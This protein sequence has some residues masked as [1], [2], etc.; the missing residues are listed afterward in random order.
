MAEL[1]Y[2][3][4]FF[5]Y[6][7]ETV[8]NYLPFQARRRKRV[9][10]VYLSLFAVW[11]EAGM[12]RLS[13]LHV[14]LAVCRGWQEAMADAVGLPSLQSLC[15]QWAWSSS[16]WKSRCRQALYAPQRTDTAPNVFVCLCVSLL[17]FVF[18][19]LPSAGFNFSTRLLNPCRAACL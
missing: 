8:L 12:W 13:W 2:F 9:R 18:V 16:Q 3:A 19:Y 7:L 5:W 15:W 4:W 11:C 10:S 14:N 1:I 6:I 17:L